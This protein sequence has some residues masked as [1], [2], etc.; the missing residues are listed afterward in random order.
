MIQ[1]VAANISFAPIGLLD[2]FNSGGAVE[3][4]EFEPA[5]NKPEHFDGEASS[6]LTGP[7]S[8]KRSPS[9]KITQKVRGCG[10]FGAYSSQRPLKCIVDGA[11][12]NFDYEETSGLV[13]LNIPVPQEEMYRWNIEVLV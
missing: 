13:T 5:S 4:F 6:E 8:E 1:E 10:R 2:M 11:E 9:A 7:L 3:Q 12:A